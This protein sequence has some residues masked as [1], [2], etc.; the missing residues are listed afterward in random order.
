MK[1]KRQAAASRWWLEGAKG[2]RW[3]VSSP[4]LPLFG[5]VSSSLLLVCIGV[6]FPVL[7]Y[8]WLRGGKC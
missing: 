8:D 6:H 2:C 4:H 7:W 1:Q 3:L 5:T